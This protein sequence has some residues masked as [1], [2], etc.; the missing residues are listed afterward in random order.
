[1]S[2]EV[3]REPTSKPPDE[4]DEKDSLNNYPDRSL[5]TGE[6]GWQVTEE[7]MLFKEDPFGQS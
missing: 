6:T 1:M 4:D 7:E 2:A 3:E 5:N